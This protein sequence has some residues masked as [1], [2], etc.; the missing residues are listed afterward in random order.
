MIK[1]LQKENGLEEELKKYPK[2]Q[3]NLER[4]TK[5][6][7]FENIPEEV[8]NNIKKIFVSKIKGR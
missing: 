7:L 8:S 6:I 2:A 4:N 1:L 3:E 5:I